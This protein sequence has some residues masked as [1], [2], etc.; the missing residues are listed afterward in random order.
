MIIESVLV[1]AGLLCGGVGLLGWLVGC[2]GVA[3]WCG[4]LGVVLGLGGIGLAY[5]S[6][7]FLLW[8]RADDDGHEEGV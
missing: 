3:R 1:L 6:S 5:Y 7:I 8:T 4:G 2:T